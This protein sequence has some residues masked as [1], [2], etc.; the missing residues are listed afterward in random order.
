MVSCLLWISSGH[1]QY[2]YYI[3]IHTPL[4]HVPQRTATLHS[5]TRLRFLPRLHN[6]IFGAE[7]CL[8]AHK[9]NSPKTNQVDRVSQEYV[10]TVTRHPSASRH[11]LSAL[12]CLGKMGWVGFTGSLCLCLFTKVFWE[13]VGVCRP[14]FS[15]QASLDV[16]TSKYSTSWMKVKP[17]D[18]EGVS[19]EGYWHS[20]GAAWG[21][22]PP[23]QCGSPGDRKPSM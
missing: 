13:L 3:L 8:P 6:L 10:G 18:W 1:T 7:V 23:P 22:G 4:I 19:R 15:G 5:G 12:R 17:T 21:I 20:E 16:Y 11:C 14:R 2:Y 9:R